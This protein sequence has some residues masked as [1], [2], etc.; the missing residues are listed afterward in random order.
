MCPDPPGRSVTLVLREVFA[1]LIQL[2]SQLWIKLRR[3]VEHRLVSVIS[4]Q[5]LLR[6]N[7]LVPVVYGTWLFTMN[8]Q[9]IIVD[10]G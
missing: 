7:C 6:K 3:I 9:G 8:I 2:M 4:Y 5:N 1:L 10:S